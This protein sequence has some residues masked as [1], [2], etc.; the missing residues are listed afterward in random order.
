MVF[1]CFQNIVIFSKFYN[2]SRKSEGI[3]VFLDLKDINVKKYFKNVYDI[4][5]CDDGS[6]WPVRFTDKL[7]SVYNVDEGKRIRSFCPSGVCMELVTDSSFLNLSVKTLDF[8][9]NFAYFDLYID[10]VFVKTIGAEPVESLPE[11]ISFDLYHKHING[12]VKGD[13]K[14]Q[15]ITI[16]LPHLVGVH[17]KA[18]E[19]E[20]GSVV[21]NCYNGC[22][23]AEQKK[24]LLC[25]GDSI[26]QG[27]TAKSPSSTYPVQLAKVLGMN[28]IN[29]GVGGYIF[30]EK[31]IDEEMDINPDIITVA[32]GVN[33]WFRYNSIDQFREMCHNFFNKLI[34]IYPKAKIFAITPVW[35]SSEGEAKAV[36]YLSEIRKEIEQVVCNFN[37][38]HVIDGLKMVPNM[39]EYFVDGV[40]PNELGFMHYSVNLLN[41]IVKYI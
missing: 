2:F 18:I 33:D 27:M 21:G 3:A 41:E 10:D 8:A 14:K 19:I 5:I 22:N 23:G 17:I 30:D 9:R 32:Y 16:Y 38:V 6:L 11:T 25:L 31:S 39:P 40:H 24:F 26:T 28:M 29:H 34:A 15:K 36:G 4:K 1:C 13:K 35:C 20:D 7:F 37:T 12:K